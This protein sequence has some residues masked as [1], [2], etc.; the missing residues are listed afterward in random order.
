V[1]VEIFIYAI[2]Q[3]WEELVLKGC[4]DP[5]FSLYNARAF[6][7]LKKDYILGLGDIA[8][9]SIVGGHRDARDK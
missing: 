3:R 8:D 5:Y 9:F 7:K 6:I 2:V 4:D 1:L